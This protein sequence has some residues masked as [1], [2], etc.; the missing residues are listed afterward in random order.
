MYSA[1]RTREPDPLTVD[2]FKAINDHDDDLVQIVVQ[3]G[4]DV[5]RGTPWFTPEHPFG[6]RA[7]RLLP[8]GVVPLYHAIHA[9]NEFAV[10]FLLSEGAVLSSDMFIWQKAVGLDAVEAPRIFM[11]LFNHYLDTF[12]SVGMETRSSKAV[13]AWAQLDAAAIRE[14][15]NPLLFHAVKN[16]TLDMLETMLRTGANIEIQSYTNNMYLLQHCLQGFS[17]HVFNGVDNASSRWIKSKVPICDLLLKYGAAREFNATNSMCLR[18]AV[19]NNE[20]ECIPL[21]RLLLSHGFGFQV[22]VDVPGR[23]P[24]ICTA[25]S[26]Q[27]LPDWTCHALLT[28]LAPFR[29]RYDVHDMK[30][31]TPLFLATSIGSGEVVE[32]LL[33]NMS[34]A[35]KQVLCTDGMLP[36]HHAIDKMNISVLKVL[37]RNGIGT[38]SVDERCG[39]TPLCRILQTKDYEYFGGRGIV[40]EFVTARLSLI[41][42]GQTREHPLM[43]IMDIVNAK[44]VRYK[45]YLGDDLFL[46]LQELSVEQHIERRVAVAMMTHERLAHR[47]DAASY[48]MCPEVL[49]MVADMCDHS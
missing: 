1:P 12:D 4:A 24:I 40:N 19:C 11:S 45:R 2:L 15:R 49:G 25:L 34:Q 27:E 36:I 46:M 20:S 21:T 37:I 32:L 26:E 29:P 14:T 16:G 47:H 10:A 38:E 39:K 43:S 3:N 42:P 28:L 44:T 41:T 35:E 48:Q 33:S 22:N 31:R 17:C 30:G 8:C 9:H 23:S 18:M 13:I 6:E 7:N 5:N